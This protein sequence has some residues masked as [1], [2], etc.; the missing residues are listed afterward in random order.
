M[1]A[2]TNYIYIILTVVYLIYS[3]VKAGKKV[4]KNRPTIDPQSQSPQTVQPPTATL[5]PRQD[6]TKMLEDLLGGVPEEKIPEPEVIHSK[7]QPVAIK[8]QLTKIVTHA[9]KKEKIISSHLHSHPNDEIKHQKVMTKEVIAEPVAVEEP[10][11]NFD[12]REAIIYSTIL[13]RPEY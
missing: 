3:V 6:F 4:T 9:V 5:P 13:E 1:H 11:T 7:P 12:F 10:E 2:S 8:P